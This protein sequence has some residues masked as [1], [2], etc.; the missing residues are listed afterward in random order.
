MAG[1]CDHD[2]VMLTARDGAYCLIQCR[3]CGWHTSECADEES[4]GK[5]W[6]DRKGEWK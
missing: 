3:C 1:K 4:A 6:Q 2:W 5:E